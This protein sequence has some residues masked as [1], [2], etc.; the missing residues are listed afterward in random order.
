[1]VAGLDVGGG[2]AETVVFVCETEAHPRRIIK[3]GAWRADD[4]GVQQYVSW[5]RIEIGLRVCASMEPALV[6]TL[7]SICATRRRHSRQ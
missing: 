5:R 2:E 7:V 4:S 6:T 3:M 1:L